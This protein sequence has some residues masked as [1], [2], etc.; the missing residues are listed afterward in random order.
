MTINSCSH[1]TENHC[2]QVASYERLYA[3]VN[4]AMGVC[5]REVERESQIA[6]NCALSCQVHVR[7]RRPRV[8]PI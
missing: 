8:G 2:V 1:S 7:L 3:D 4:K 6:S 5:L